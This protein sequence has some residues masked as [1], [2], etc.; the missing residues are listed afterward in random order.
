MEKNKIIPLFKD[1]D[2]PYGACNKCD[3]DDFKILLTPSNEEFGVVGFQCSGCGEY[4]MFEEVILEV[5][6]DTES[7]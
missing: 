2:F 7:D 5:N 6:G 4:V 1:P 3:C